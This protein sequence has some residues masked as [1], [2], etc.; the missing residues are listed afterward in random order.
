MKKKGIS[1]KSDGAIIKLTSEI[2][3]E[4]IEEQGNC[5]AY[6]SKAQIRRQKKNLAKADKQFDRILHHNQAKE[7]YYKNMESLAQIEKL[8]I[9]LAAVKK[10]NEGLKKE[11]NDFADALVAKVEEIEK[12]KSFW[13]F[14]KY[15]KL[16]LELIEVI[17]Q[18]ITLLKT[19]AVKNT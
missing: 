9:E 3:S 7:K 11:A 18:R 5:F 6:A 1:R 12:T 19:R 14:F 13:N 2:I 10:E 16:V 4:I 15:A 17:R 8:Q